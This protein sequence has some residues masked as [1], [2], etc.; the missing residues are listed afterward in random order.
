MP[1]RSPSVGVAG[2]VGPPH[3]TRA[4]RGYISLFVNRR[5]IQNRRLA[6]AV[7]EAYQGLLMVGRRP[8]AVLNLRVPH[9]E[10][11]VNVHPTKAEVRFRERIC[12]LRRDPAGRAAGATRR[13]AG[14]RRE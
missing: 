1:S 13:R 12:C 11:D 8:L 3:L 5:W 2:L 7:E 14:P 10:V 6:Y 9:D 4:G